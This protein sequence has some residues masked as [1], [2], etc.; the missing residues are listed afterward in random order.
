MLFRSR[1]K[2]IVE[3][4]SLR[5]P[6]SMME[7]SLQSDAWLD[8]T[9]YPD[10]SF[11]VISFDNVKTDGDKTTA[12]VTGT[13]TLHGVSNKITVPVKMSFLKDKLHDR[14]PKLQGDLLVV[15]ASFT[16]KRSD[17]GINK[18]Q[19]EDKVSDEIE[20]T[21]SLAGQSPR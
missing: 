20:L 9:K 3:T 16:I 6:N 10:I 7:K 15:R 13:F 21:L 8:A 14:F 12:D 19:F 4:V 17:Y 1:G 18:A 11:E 5:V 2:I